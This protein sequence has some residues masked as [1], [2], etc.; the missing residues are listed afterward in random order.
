VGAIALVA[1]PV[2]GLAGVA[3]AADDEA[4]SGRG[5]KPTLTDEQRQCLADQGVT[6]PE[7]PAEGSD[8]STRVRP[9][10]EQRSAFRAAAEACGLPERPHHRHGA[11]P[12]LTD[13]Q[14][15]CLA[16]Q[17]VTLPDRP[18][19]GSDPS[20]RVRPTEEQRS[21]FRAAAEACGLPGPPERPADAPGGVQGSS[22]RSTALTA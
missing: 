16:D 22:T 7:R 13:E 9:T 10:E 15:Q 8:P 12:A 5:P 21:A 18:A 17:G 3:D 19:A 6:L 2:L 4:G 11:R 20:T 14:K 1:V